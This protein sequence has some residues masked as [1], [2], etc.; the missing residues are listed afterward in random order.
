[1]ITEEVTYTNLKTV[2]TLTIRKTTP[3][4]I[5]VTEEMQAEMDR[6]FARFYLRLLENTRKKRLEEEELARGE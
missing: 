6:R 5:E 3:P 1:M 2:K 4:D